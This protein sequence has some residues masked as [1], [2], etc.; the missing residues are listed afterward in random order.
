MFLW[1][2][3]LL[4]ISLMKI[5]MKLCKNLSKKNISQNL[6]GK[7]K[8]MTRMVLWKLIQTL[9]FL[10]VIFLHDIFLNLHLLLW[11]NLS[12]DNVI[13]LMMLSLLILHHASTHIFILNHP[14]PFNNNICSFCTMHQH[15][16]SFSISIIPLVLALIKIILVQMVVNLSRFTTLNPIFKWKGSFNLN[17]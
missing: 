8:I 4:F 14:L 12:F 16:Y 11:G 7:K 15:T 10:K 1:V 6:R 13:L 5:R 2:L 9:M 3:R 17:N